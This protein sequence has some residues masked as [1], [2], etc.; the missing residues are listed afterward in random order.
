VFLGPS[1]PVV[2]K[3]SA[4]IRKPVEDVFRF[5]GEDFFENYPKWSPEVKELKRL[6][7]GPLGVG[8]TGRQVRVD[9]GR[10]SESDFK[11]L[12]FQPNRRAVFAGAGRAGEVSGS[13]AFKCTYDV[14]DAR[15]STPCT[16]VAFTFEIPELELFMRPFEKLIRVAIEEGA[17][18]TVR[19]IKSLIEKG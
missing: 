16:R 19:N 1:K 2:G 6:S 18:S 9:C 15:L 4:I 14:N 3:A 11:V 10:R 12:E 7:D 5:I 8:T 13:G 17:E